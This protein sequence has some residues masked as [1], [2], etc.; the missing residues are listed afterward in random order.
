MMSAD[1]AVDIFQ[2]ALPLLDGDAA[3]QD[4]GVASFVKFPLNN[5]ERL[6]TVCELLSLRFVSWEDLVEEAIEIRCPPVGQRVRLCHWFFV[7]L[8]D[9]E[10]GRSRWLVSPRA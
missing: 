9:L 6:G 1:P 7:K 5:D 2:Q 4:L 3:L 10:V 8:H